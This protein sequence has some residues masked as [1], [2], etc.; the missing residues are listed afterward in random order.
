MNANPLMEPGKIHSL[1]RKFTVIQKFSVN[2]LSFFFGSCS[3]IVLL[4]NYFYY[5]ATSQ[6][7]PDSDYLHVARQEEQLERG[8]NLLQTDLFAKLFLCCYSWELCVLG[9]NRKGGR[10]V[11]GNRDNVNWA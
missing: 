2:T 9:P 6:D 3:S 10:I 1:E 4:D 11:I 7:L 8:D 5:S